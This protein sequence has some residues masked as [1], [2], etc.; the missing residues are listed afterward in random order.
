M[1]AGSSVCETV[2]WTDPLTDCDHYRHGPN[3]EAVLKVP[4][5]EW[6]DDPLATRLRISSWIRRVHARDC[7]GEEDAHAQPAL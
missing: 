1:T 4:Y 6:V 5:S 2:R 7:H 3:P